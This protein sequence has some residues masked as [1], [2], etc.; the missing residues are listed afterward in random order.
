MTEADM[1]DGCMCDPEEWDAPVTQIC[2]SFVADSG[3]FVFCR[4]CDHER[5]CHADADGES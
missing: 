2:D 1:P 3:G 4:K 5:L